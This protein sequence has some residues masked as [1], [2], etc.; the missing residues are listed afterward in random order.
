[1]DAVRGPGKFFP[2]ACDVTNEK[3]V[4]RAFEWI[5]KNFQTVHILVNNAGILKSSTIEGCY[6]RK[7]RLFRQEYDYDDFFAF[8]EK[9]RINLNK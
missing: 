6:L 7:M 2:Q 5:E 1:M 8:F 4:N 9:M 3:A